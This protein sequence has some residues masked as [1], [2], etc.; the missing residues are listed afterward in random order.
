MARLPVLIALLLTATGA[1][2]ADLCATVVAGSPPV[3]T[4]KATL[5]ADVKAFVVKT[6]PTFQDQVIELYPL[7]KDG[8]GVAIHYEGTLA[9]EYLV[10]FDRT[11]GA[12]KAVV[13]PDLN[14]EADE[15]FEAHVATVGG[16]PVLFSTRE[17]D[18][19]K[20]TRIA[21]WLGHAFGPI[22]ETA[23]K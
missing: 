9:T 16:A 6:D 21:P 13:L 18:G 4:R 17:V 2:A 1:R 5:P 19:K 20:H 14:A 12:L 23:A 7:G 11:K 3:L 10:A 22:C 15:Y 8:A